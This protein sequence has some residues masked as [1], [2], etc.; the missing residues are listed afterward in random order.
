L[1]QRLF[2]SHESLITSTIIVLIRSGKIV[3][4]AIYGGR[5][6]FSSDSGE[7]FTENPSTSK[8]YWSLIAMSAD[9]N[10]ASAFLKATRASFATLIVFKLFRL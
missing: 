1:N 5:I 9:G 4:A 6:W 2:E 10:R 7:T 3:A 8:L